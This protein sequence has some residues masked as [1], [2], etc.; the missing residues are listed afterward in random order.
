MNLQNRISK[1]NYISPCLIISKPKSLTSLFSVYNQTAYV[2]TCKQ[3]EK[4]Y[5]IKPSMAVGTQTKFSRI[6]C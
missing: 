6:K 5:K 3:N 1:N 2:S 4:L